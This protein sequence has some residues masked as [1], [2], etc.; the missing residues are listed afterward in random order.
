MRDLVLRALDTASQQA[1][2][3]PMPALSSGARS[4]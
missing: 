1:P 3:T 2:L 4:R